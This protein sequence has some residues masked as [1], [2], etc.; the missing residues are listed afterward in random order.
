MTI[1]R[2]RP[3]PV[4]TRGAGAV[5][6]RPGRATFTAFW[7]E[8]GRQRTKGGFVTD[9]DAQA[10]LDRMVLI[11]R[12]GTVD[13]S[14]GSLTVT[15]FVEVFLTAVEAEHRRGDRKASTLSSYRN[16]L[17]YAQRDS[18]LSATRL[19]DVTGSNLGA[20]Y[21]RLRR[22]GKKNGTGVAEG[23]VR[24]VHK[25]LSTMF[26]H[27]VE[28]RAVPTA[29]TADVPSRQRSRAQSKARQARALGGDAVSLWRWETVAELCNSTATQPT[30]QRIACCLAAAAS[31]RVGEICGLVWGDVDLDAYGNI[32]TVNVKRARSVVDGVVVEGTP[33]SATSARC[34]PLV[35]QLRSALVAWRNVQREALLAQ[36]V[37]VTKHTPV[38]SWI[39][40]SCPVRGVAS[41]AGDQWRSDT[42]SRKTQD[43]LSSLGL[44]AVDGL[45]ALRH[46]FGFV[47][48]NDEVNGGRW[49]AA[50]VAAAMGHASTSVTLDVYNRAGTSMAVDAIAASIRAA[51]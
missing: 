1:P 34:M 10:Y 42:L 4:S 38:V 11:V 29:P 33:K 43:T 32:G 46:V 20:F 45:H 48:L 27:A 36:A 50:T 40:E 6:Q 22:S 31:L 30:A 47:F 44:P 12:S 35:P 5:R 39:A 15:Q 13:P 25:A 8:G 28:V 26:A 17:A 37:R 21:D 51:L 16:V 18:Q 7:H 23:T 24:A 14:S 3:K 49:S 41:A 9:R 19:R 2:T